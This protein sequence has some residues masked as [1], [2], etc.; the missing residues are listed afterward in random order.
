V[1]DCEINSEQQWNSEKR[2]DF[3]FRN[4]W[5]KKAWYS[6]SGRNQCARMTLF[7]RVA[8]LTFDQRKFL[9]A[10]AVLTETMTYTYQQSIG[11]EWRSAS[12]GGTWDVINPA[13]EVAFGGM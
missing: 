3:C 13:T 5:A 4:V 10:R 6:M 1:E 9:L 11:G 2:P 12:N 8:P 7:S